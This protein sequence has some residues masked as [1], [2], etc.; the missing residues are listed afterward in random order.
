MG[1]MQQLIW[2]IIAALVAPRL[3]NKIV[4]FQMN[5]KACKIWNSFYEQE[6]KRAGQK[7]KKLIQ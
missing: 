2:H 1:P 5:L 3:Q 7:K 4:K 6:K